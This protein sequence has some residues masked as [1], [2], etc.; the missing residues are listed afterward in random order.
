MNNVHLKLKELRIGKNLTQT[1]MA[2]MAGISR[3][4]YVFIEN[5]QTKTIS[6]EVGLALA[7]TLEIPFNELFEIE[8][9][10][11]DAITQKEHDELWAALKEKNKSL[12]EKNQMIELLQS[13]LRS[14][15]KNAATDEIRALFGFLHEDQASREITQSDEES[16]KLISDIKITIRDLNHTIGGN[17]EENL[18]NYNDALS[19]FFDIN[20]IFNYLESKSNSKNEF[21]EN[22]V[23]KLKGIEVLSEPEIRSFIKKNIITKWDTQ[24]I[25]AQKRRINKLFDS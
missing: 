8:C 25:K 10:Q 19:S 5:G 18:I 7:K 15:K 21:I 2:Q 13:E 14:Y 16:Q 1:Q 20:E 12:E 4:T 11:K 22:T 17:I 23:E 3:A 9:T 24:K 6:I